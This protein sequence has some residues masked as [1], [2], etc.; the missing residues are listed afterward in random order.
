MIPAMISIKS[1]VIKI[2]KP[3]LRRQ[4]IAAVNTKSKKA[5]KSIN[6]HGQVKK[7]MTLT[8]QRTASPNP[9]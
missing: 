8:I 5:A 7:A 6:F 2:S 3:I 4:K 9:R 1:S